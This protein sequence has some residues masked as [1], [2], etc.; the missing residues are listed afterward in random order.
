M[1]IDLE[2]EAVDEVEVEWDNREGVEV[3]EDHAVVV[4]VEEGVRKK[5]HPQKKIWMLNWM[6]TIQR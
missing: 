1:E 5:K 4:E 3:V 2:E 6:H